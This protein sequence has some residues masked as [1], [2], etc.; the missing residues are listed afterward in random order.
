MK[1]MFFLSLLFTL[2]LQAQL[3]WRP[4]PTAITNIDNQRFDDV[5]LLMI[6]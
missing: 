6:M 3:Q 1:K 5:F 4:L 2:T